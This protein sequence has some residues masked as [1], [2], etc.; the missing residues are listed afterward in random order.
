[1]QNRTQTQTLIL[2]FEYSVRNKAKGPQN[3]AITSFAKTNT[4]SKNCRKK[5]NANQYKQTKRDT[6]TSKDT[7]RT[8][9]NKCIQ[10]WHKRQ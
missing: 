4:Q 6:K 5:T 1:M 8:H 10:R 9:Q 3:T 7:Q 2:I